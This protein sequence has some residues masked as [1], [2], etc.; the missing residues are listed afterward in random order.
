MERALARKHLVEDRAEGEDVRPVIGR[1]SPDL[2]R[3]HVADRPHHDARFGRD[4]CRRGRAYGTPKRHEPGEAEVEQLDPAFVRDEDV[5]G[6]QVPMDD[7]LFVGRREAGSDLERVLDRPR[8]MRE[9]AA[10][11]PFAETSLEQLHRRGHLP[12]R[13]AEIEDA[14]DVRMRQGRAALASRSNRAS[15]SA[16]PARRSGRILTATSRSSFVSRARYTSP[17]PPAPSGERI[18]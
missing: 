11:E 18:S 9:S 1:P 16:S 4:G 2:L 12:C 13:G 14:Q 15:A 6:L 8:A 7:S 5:L 3:R 10:R 17:I